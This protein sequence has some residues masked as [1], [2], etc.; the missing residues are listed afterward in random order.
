MMDLIG[1]ARQTKDAIEEAHSSIQDANVTSHVAEQ[2]HDHAVRQSDVFEANLF[3]LGEGPLP[4]APLQQTSPTAAFAAPAFATP[5]QQ[6]Q[7]QQQQIAPPA[8][9]HHNH[10]NHHQFEQQQH[11]PLRVP[12]MSQSEVSAF[13]HEVSLAHH[14]TA[15]DSIDEEEENDQQG[16]W[17]GSS[18]P[19]PVAGGGY[20]GAPQPVQVQAVSPAQSLIHHRQ[21][22]ANAFSSD[23]VMGGSADPLPEVGGMSPPSAMAS[24]NSNYGYDDQSE[25]DL[26]NVS[27][28]KKK[29]KAAENAARDAQAAHRKLAAEADELRQD[30][31][32]AEGNARSLKAAATE[33]KKG[34]F[35]RGKKKN[36]E[37]SGINVCFDLFADQE[38]THI[39]FSISLY[40]RKTPKKP[41]KTLQQLR[42]G[43]SRSNR[44]HTMPSHSQHRLI[45][46]RRS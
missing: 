20:H 15:V 36:Q 16:A 24:T 34:A 21:I 45:A 25:M 14:V 33:K 12:A 17:M 13:S 29:V 37:V 43:F 42:R 23:M 38:L 46:N 7:Q 10:N 44:K 32:K 27:E 2:Q 41:L 18:G 39:Y 28:L 8:Q 3:D 35:G 30:A 19:A 5:G 11:P 31:D 1:E 6:Q 22:S 26:A 9:R 40:F 4:G